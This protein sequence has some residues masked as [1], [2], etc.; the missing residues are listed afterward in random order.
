MGEGLTKEGW[1]EGGMVVEVGVIKGRK[2]GRSRIGKGFG[3][4][5]RGE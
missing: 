3:Y 4:C 5:G 2:E 1:D